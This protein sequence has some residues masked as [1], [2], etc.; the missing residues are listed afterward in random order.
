MSAEKAAR[1][2]LVRAVIL[3]IFR[4]PA[5]D[6][7]QHGKTNLSPRAN[8]SLIKIVAASGENVDNHV[9]CRMP[10]ALIA[11]SLDHSIASRVETQRQPP[12]VVVVIFKYI[13]P[14]ES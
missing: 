3:V 9:V 7:H 11:Y 14:D 4:H 1:E 13:L 8:H 2:S 10:S 6:R 5:I 12:G